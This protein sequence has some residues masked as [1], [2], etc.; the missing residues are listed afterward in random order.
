MDLVLEIMDRPWSWGESDCC[1]AACDVFAALHGIDPMAGLRG[2]YA[3][4]AE[5][6]A[7]IAREG[8][9]DALAARLAALSG[10]RRSEGRAG[11]IG[12]SGPG[13]ASGGRAL[14]ICVGRGWA[15]KSPRGFSVL[16]RAEVAW[17]V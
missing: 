9:L 15:G 4:R 1:A 17:G 10:L 12:V 2:T 13:A 3:S 6:E 8:G 16:P 7:M 11:D 5:A 14:L